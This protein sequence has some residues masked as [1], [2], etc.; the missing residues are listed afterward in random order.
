MFVKSNFKCPMEIGDHYCLEE[1]EKRTVS[2]NFCKTVLFATVS[3]TTKNIHIS[4]IKK[5][6]KN[7]IVW[8]TNKEE[9][10]FFGSK[11]NFAEPN[12]S[13]CRIQFLFLSEQVQCLG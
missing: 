5:W 2:R 12:Y 3:Q 6:L 10:R 11:F 8:S 1:I 7:V 9:N 13:A 4:Y